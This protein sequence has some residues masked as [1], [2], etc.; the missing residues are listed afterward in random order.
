MPATIAHLLE[1]APRVLPELFVK[2]TLVLAAAGALSLTLRRASAS[3]RHLVWAVAIA[4]VVA[5]ALT[6]LLPRRFAV[7]PSFA[8]PSADA[9]APRA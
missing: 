6:P 2:S 8:A 4:G 7:L 3:A 1:A 5:L 9:W